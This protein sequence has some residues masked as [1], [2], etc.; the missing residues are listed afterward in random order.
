M[1]FKVKKSYH[2]QVDK[3]LK[4]NVIK[5]QNIIDMASGKIPKNLIFYQIYK[6]SH[7]QIYGKT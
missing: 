1:S 5:S 6:Y 2:D 4:M 3:I 7:D